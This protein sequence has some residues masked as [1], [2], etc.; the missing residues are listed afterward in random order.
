MV[1]FQRVFGHSTARPCRRGALKSPAQSRLSCGIGKVGRSGST[2]DAAPR[3]RN[4]L[5][6]DP[7]K[8]KGQPLAALPSLVTLFLEAAAEPIFHP[9]GE[10]TAGTL[11][12]A[13]TRAR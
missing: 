3:H 12:P 13:L 4:V 7:R 5:R 1:S 9:A 11:A 8:Q 6:L 10:G 2:G